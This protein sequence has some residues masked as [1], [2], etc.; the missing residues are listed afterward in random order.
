MP[1]IK[2]S[3]CIAG[4]GPA[5]MMLGYLL[6]RAGVPVIVLEKYADFFR[7]FRGDTIHPSTLELMH[8]LGLGEAFLKLPHQRVDEL[9]AVFSGKTYTLADFRH[10]PVRYPFIAFVPQWDFLTFLSAE[11]RKLPNFR[12]LMQT[13]ALDLI[14]DSG[15]VRGALAKGPGGPF[16]ITANLIVG[17]DGRHSTVREKSGLRIETLGSPIDALWFR[18]SRLAGDPADPAG[19]FEAGRIFVML[20]RGDYWQCAYVIPK[21]SFETIKSDGVAVFQQA[22]R[23]AAPFLEERVAEITNFAQLSLLTVLVDRALSWHRPG[24]LLIGDA[25]HAMSPVGGV[26]VN[27]AVQDAVA[28]ANALWR[29]LREGRPSEADLAK[30]QARR[31]TA[32]RR[33]QALQVMIQNRVIAP[34][35]ASTAG[36]EIAPP[37]PIRLFNAVPVLRRIP[38]RLIG[39]GMQPEHISSPEL[40]PA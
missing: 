5:G 36:T 33:T 40:P 30:V 22:L 15:D 21:G 38:A 6:A 27:L 1:D 13:E 2:T 37:W 10:L 32:T 14:V 18:V 16:R 28:A 3:V 24:L 9:Q 29:T 11:A 25:A 20:N 31:Q 35:L 7:D 17:A 23:R 12:L 34:A 4:G 19:R 39:L 26:G 8:E